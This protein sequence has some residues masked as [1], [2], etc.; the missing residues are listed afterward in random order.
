MK[1]NFKIIFVVSVLF[2]FLPVFVKAVSLGEKENFFIDS[3]YD[4][5]GREQISA[6]L[7]RIGNDAYF[8]IDDDWWKGLDNSER[9]EVKDWLMILDNE[10]HSRIYPILI[11]KFGLEWR[12]GIDK[13]ARITILIHSM[14]EEAGGY[15]SAKDEYPKIQFPESNEREMIYINANHVTDPIAKSLVAHEFM[16]LITFNQKEKI[17]GVSEEV[18]LN[19][20]RAEFTSTLLGYDNVYQGSNLEKRVE[21][22]LENPSDSITEWKGK[23]A[24]YGVLNVFTQY[25]VDHYGIEILSDSL[26]SQKTGIDSLNYALQ[27]NGFEKKFSQVFTEWTIAVVVNDCSLGKY[28]CYK[29]KHLQNLLIKPSLNFLPLNAKSTLGV[30]QS[31]KNWAG[32]WFKL[33]GGSGSLK[34]EFI[35]NPENLFKVSYIV[36]SSSGPTINSFSLNEYQRGE[37]SVSGLN[38][39]VNSIIIIPTI[40]SKTSG[41]SSNEIPVSY[42]WSVSVADEEQEVSKYLEK[43]VFQMSKNEILNKIVEIEDLLNQLRTRLNAINNPFVPE[44]VSCNSFNQNLFFGLTNDSR[45]RCLQEFLKNQGSDIYP[46]GL[47]TGNFLSLTRAAVIRFQ[48]KY[49]SSIL[50]PLGLF[51][52]TGYVGP[53]T[54]AKINKLLTP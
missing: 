22:F 34:I 24:D 52:G 40:Q 43:P 36:N 51:K 32:N 15:F 12:P 37:I 35:G 23:E 45:V 18:W 31:T 27:L 38:K 20:A 13:D 6:T 25:L 49:A 53:N 33:I 16:H 48:E 47:V 5:L 21:T 4:L 2:V 19:E 3:D 39:D 30:S 41:F 28:Y 17:R 26:K 44:P 46:E 10:F 29:N 9:T 14:R 54:R 1:K 50:N 8:Y 42:F 11:S 7:Q